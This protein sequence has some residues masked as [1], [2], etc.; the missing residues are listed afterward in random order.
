VTTLPLA[1]APVSPDVTCPLCGFAYVPGGASCR[2][3]GC[4]I[5]LGTCA[6]RHCPRCGYTMPDEERSTAARLVRLLFRPRPRRDGATLADLPSG[7]TATIERLEGDPALLARLTA[8]GLAPGVEIH[9]VQRTPTHVI[10]LGQTTVAVERRV[11]ES[12]RVRG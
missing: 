3:H 11:A 5:A 6:T 10:E 2:E 12:I 9:V 4:P 8:Q 7:A 1:G